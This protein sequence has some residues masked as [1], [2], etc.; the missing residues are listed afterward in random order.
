MSGGRGVE[1]DLLAQG[2]RVRERWDIADVLAFVR[3]ELSRNTPIVLAFY[4]V[5]LGLLI[6]GA[7]AAVALVGSGTRWFTEVLVPLGAG[8][9]MMLVVVVPHELLHGLAYKAI[10]APEV[11]YGANLRQL[12]F[13]ASAPFFPVRY[14]QMAFVALLPFA[15]ITAALTV[16]LAVLGGAWWWA[17]YGLA[18]MH[19]QGCLGDVAMV[20]F[21]ARQE[22]P[23]RWA[24]F[25]DGDEQ[26]FVMLER[27]S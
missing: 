26:T 20:S 1:A 17:C 10:G 15:V 6:L 18:L 3:R 25:D 12:V 13:H 11:R 21:F 14:A 2:Y 23:A 16:G 22:E 4:A 27:A 24:T 19:T 9:V 7:A 5:L 8:M